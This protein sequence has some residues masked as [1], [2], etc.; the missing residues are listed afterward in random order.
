MTQLV[1][2]LRVVNLLL[3][4]IYAEQMTWTVGAPPPNWAA[5]RDRWQLAHTVRTG[6]AVT[7]FCCQIAAAFMAQAT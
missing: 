3:G 2:L 1:I 6:L 5:I 4:G 7:G